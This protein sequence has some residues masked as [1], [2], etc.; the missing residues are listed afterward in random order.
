MARR[1][2]PTYHQT[3]AS[4]TDVVRL[5]RSD[6]N[7]GPLGISGGFGAPKEAL[8]KAFDRGVTYWYHGSRRAPGMTGAVRELGGAGKRDQLVLVLQSYSRWSWLLEKTFTAGL[9]KLKTD[10]ADVLLLGW[11][12]A[13]PAEAILER[14]L[15]LQRRGLCRHIAISCHHRPS[16]VDYARDE[17][18][19]VTHLRYN[20][21]HTGAEQDVFPHL[22]EQ[23]RPGFV[24]FTA[25]RWKSLLKPKLM[26][27]GETPM[28]ARD[29]YRFVLS[30]PHIDVCMTGPANADQVDEALA[31]LDKGPVSDEEGQRFRRI[32]AHVRANAGWRPLG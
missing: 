30:Q 22:D 15:E 26:P 17:R 8:L 18:F 7:V 31:A 9:R 14:A 12:N 24:A 32:G 6:L 25:T 16:F 4:F 10:Y 3:M 20:A 23:D 11:H 2:R 13:L 1:R 5:G 29:C 19:G 28:S 27:A 21:A